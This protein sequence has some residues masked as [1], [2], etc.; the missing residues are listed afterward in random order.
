MRLRDR[1]AILVVLARNSGVVLWAWREERRGLPRRRQRLAR[2]LERPV[3]P[4]NPTSYGEKLL[5]RI[6]YD[7]DPILVDWSDKLRMRDHIRRIVGDEVARTHLPRLIWTGRNPARIPFDSLDVPVVI[8]PNN[9]T[10]RVLR[11]DPATSDNRDEVIA[12]CRHWMRG[13]HGIAGFLW[14]V[15][16]IPPCLMVEAHVGAGDPG[17]VDEYKFFV[18]GGRV[19]FGIISRRATSEWSTFDADFNRLD[20]TMGGMKNIDKPIP[21]MDKPPF[22]DE[23]CDHAVA[24]VDGRS[25]LR[26]DFLVANGHWWFG[27][28]TPFSSGSRER[29]DPAAFDRRMAALWMEHEAG[30]GNRLARG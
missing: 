27:E 5:G 21:E 17:A 1:L 4:D 13:L 26:V 3:D 7:R 10:A 29:I 9:S 30:R 28:L 2:L 19:L 12:T 18:V 15:W 11:W 23:I 22:W 20:V 8:K 25:V 24:L 14:L 16:R 6:L